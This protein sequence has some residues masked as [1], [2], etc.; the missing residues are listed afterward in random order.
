MSFKTLTAIALL[1]LSALS[2]SASA[3]NWTISVTGHVTSGIDNFGIFGQ[4]RQDLTGLFYTQTMTAS[5]DAGERA[6]GGGS[7]TSSFTVKDRTVSFTSYGFI[8]S[9]GTDS[10]GIQSTLT[11]YVVDDDVITYG[12]DIWISD[13]YA[14]FPNNPIDFNIPQS[15]SSPAWGFSRVRYSVPFNE[16]FAVEGSVETVSITTS[17]PEPSTYAM[18]LLGLSLAGYAARKR[19]SASS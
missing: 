16:L 8:G 10:D 2:T 6:N 4:W 9:Q 15:F 3:T 7:F 17:V 5:T 12:R 11:G 1:S 13:I 19:R 14:Y 18:M